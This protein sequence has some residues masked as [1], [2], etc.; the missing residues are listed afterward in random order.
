MT[1]YTY[2]YT[3]KLADFADTPFPKARPRLWVEG[4]TASMSQSSVH[5][6][7]RVEVPVAETGH[8]SVALVASAD[9]VPPTPYILRCEWLDGDTVLGWSTWKFTDLIGGG[10]IANMQDGETTNVWYSTQSPPANRGGI[11]W[12]NPVTG[13][14][15]EWV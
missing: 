2:P 12:I 5:A 7:K 4:E 10:N 3:G 11:I 9:L 14:V 6:L 1:T 8:F 13:D 15:R